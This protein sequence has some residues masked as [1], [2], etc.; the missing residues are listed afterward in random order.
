M[1]K[2]RSLKHSDVG[3]RVSEY[4]C[5]CKYCYFK[6]RYQIKNPHQYDGS[7]PN[8]KL[9]VFCKGNKGNNKIT[10]FRTILQRESKNS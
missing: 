9:N 3:L 5:L 10:E 1:N 4:L 2:N 8:Q 6:M 7:E